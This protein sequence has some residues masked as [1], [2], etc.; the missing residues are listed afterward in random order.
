MLKDIVN[1]CYD[2]TVEKQKA[3]S[4]NVLERG[5]ATVPLASLHVPFHPRYLWFGAMPF[6]GREWTAPHACMRLSCSFQI[7]REDSRQSFGPFAFH[8]GLYPQL[9][10]ITIRCQ[11]GLCRAHK[12]SALGESNQVRFPPPCTP[13]A[14]S[15]TVSSLTKQ[16]VPSMKPHL[17]CTLRKNQSP[18]LSSSLIVPS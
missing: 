17:R 18:M 6:W 8:G 11:Q 13:R 10:R 9:G 2:G 14:T 5:L 12:S 1:S 16:L 7:F 15:P 4:Y 3:D